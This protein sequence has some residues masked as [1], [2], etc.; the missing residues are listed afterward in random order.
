[1]LITLKRVYF[2]VT[3]SRKTNFFEETMDGI[4]LRCLS[5][6]PSRTS[7]RPRHNSSPNLESPCN[8]SRFP[9]ATEFARYSHNSRLFELSY[10]RFENHLNCYSK[11]MG[12]AYCNS[13]IKRVTM[14]SKL[15]KGR[16][17]VGMYQQTLLL[18]GS[19]IGKYINLQS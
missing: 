4:I 14:K 19:L 6:R 18:W 16:L 17:A 8:S 1:M 5:V 10:R 2:A 12:L 13:L 11:Y 7:R 9:C 3:A 15:R